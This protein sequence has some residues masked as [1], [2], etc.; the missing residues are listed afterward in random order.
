MLSFR[1]RPGAI[2]ILGVILIVTALWG[3]WALQTPGL[4]F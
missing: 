4:F 2:V 3:A 1:M